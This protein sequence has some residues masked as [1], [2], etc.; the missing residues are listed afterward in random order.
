MF[1][2]IGGG[3]TIH[4]NTFS[5]LFIDAVHYTHTNSC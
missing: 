2:M 5:N 4:L 1:K 3:S